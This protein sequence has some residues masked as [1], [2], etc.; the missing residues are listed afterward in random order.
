VGVLPI[1]VNE[2]TKLMPYLADQDKA[3][4]AVVRLGVVT[5]TQDMTGRVLATCAVPPL[6]RSTLEGTVRGFV[7]RI[8]QVPPMYSAL[9]HEGRRLHEL[10]REGVEVERKAR[11]IT[12]HSI[13]VE[14]IEPPTVTLSIVCGK[15]TYVRTLA[16]DL[17]AALGCGAAVEALARTRVGPFTREGA[18]S[19]NEITTAS[20][21]VLWDRALPSESALATWSV[22]TLDASGVRAFVHGQ[23]AD[24]PDGRSSEGDRFVV[25]KD[26]HGTFLGVGERVSRARLVRPA[27][28]LHADSARADVL[29][30]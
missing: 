7:G 22:V 6:D 4:R 19:W 5:D 2:A 15:G 3:Y 27:R 16:A 20:E 25:V 30:A 28:L 14:A 23:A 21:D 13:I 12:V 17:G 8:A 18:V 24:V 11:E 26:A 29:P 10:A 9:H 1:L